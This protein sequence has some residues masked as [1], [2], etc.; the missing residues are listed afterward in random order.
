VSELQECENHGFYGERYSLFIQAEAAF[1]QLLSRAETYYRDTN[2][3]VPVEHYKTRIKSAESAKEKLARL[4]LP[5]TPEAAASNLFDLVGIRIVCQF[6]SD[7]YALAQAICESGEMEVVAQKDYIKNPK[8]NGYRSLHLILRLSIPQSCAIH[9]VPIEVQMRTIAMDFWASLEHE[10]KYK[11]NIAD[12][13][14]MFAE[15][16]RC[17]DEIASVD[18]SMQTIYE[19]IQQSD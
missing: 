12:V 7:I 6:V 1:T 16:K 17:A 9:M 14:L 13:E 10:L 4:G 2:R 15:L 8:P 3:R 11:K 19:W 5:Q 18:L